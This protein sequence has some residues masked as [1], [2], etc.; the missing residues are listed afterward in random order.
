MFEKISEVLDVPHEFETIDIDHKDVVV[1][2]KQIQNESVAEDDFKFAREKIKDAIEKSADALND[3][4]DLSRASEHPRSYEVLANLANTV[5][6]M[7]ESLVKLHKDNSKNQPTQ[8]QINN[9]NTLVVAPTS[10]IIK[11]LRNKN[12]INQS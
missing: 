12:G 4:L 9:N 5:T 3:M 7:S 1:V 2:D 10:D 11:M 8:Q 6:S